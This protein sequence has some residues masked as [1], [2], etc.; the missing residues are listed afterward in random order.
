MT[1]V[2]ILE[3]SRGRTMTAKRPQILK[4]GT[5]DVD[6]VETTPVVFKDKLYRF[7]TAS[8][9]LQKPRLRVRSML[10]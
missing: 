8:N 4:L 5:I 1:A 6:L 9:T 3:D 2:L 10:S 7:E